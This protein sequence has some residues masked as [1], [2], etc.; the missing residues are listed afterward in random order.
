MALFHTF[1]HADI[2]APILIP[3]PYHRLELQCN[4]KQSVRHGPIS[5]TRRQIAGELTTAQLSHGSHWS[6]FPFISYQNARKKGQLLHFLLK[7]AEKEGKTDLLHTVTWPSQAICQTGEKRPTGHTQRQS[8]AVDLPL[9][10]CDCPQHA[11]EDAQKPQEHMR[12]NAEAMRRNRVEKIDEPS[13][14]HEKTCKKRENRTSPIASF[15][16]P[17]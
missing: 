1:D 5:H 7:I 2:V 14:I 11:S 8:A 15:I 3:Q 10:G 9:P 13:E 16:M 17:G 6:V 4:R 12:E